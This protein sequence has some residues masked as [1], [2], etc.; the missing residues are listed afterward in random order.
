MPTKN[1]I[2]LAHNSCKPPKYSQSLKYKRNHTLVSHTTQ[3]TV[4]RHVLNYSAGSG[5]EK[6]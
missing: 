5:K 2:K 6:Y 1:N 4:I 3:V